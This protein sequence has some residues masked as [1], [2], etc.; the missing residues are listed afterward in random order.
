MAHAQILVLEHGRVAAFGRHA[1][2]ACAMIAK[3]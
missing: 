1:A 3:A 2:L